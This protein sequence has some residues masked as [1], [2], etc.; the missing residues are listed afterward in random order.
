MMYEALVRLRWKAFLEASSADECDSALDL[1]KELNEVGPTM[2]L[3]DITQQDRFTAILT[4]YQSFIERERLENPT[5]D[6]WSSYIDMV[7]CLLLFLRA[8]REGDWKLHLASLRQ[9]LPWFFAYDRVNYARYLP[10]F[11]SE[12]DN[13]SITHPAIS[14]SF[15]AG[16]FVVQRQDRYGFAQI[17][18]DIAIEQTCN[19][20]SKTKGGMKG[21]TLKKGAVN[22]WLLSHHQ[23]V[24]IMK[25]CKLMAGKDQEG[26]ARKDLDKAR[27]ERDEQDLQN[28][29]ATI[30]AMVNPFENKGEDLI[31]I[32]SGC[33]ASK[34]TRDHLITAYSIGQNGAK[35]FVEDRMTSETDKIFNPIKTNKL[36]T[37]STI[38]K[39]AIA[40]LISETVSLNA[41]SDMFNRL[42]IIGK[43][44]DIDLEELLSY[45]LRTVPMSL[46]TTDGTPCKTVTAKLM[47]ELEKD[48]EPLAQVPAGSA[49]IVDGMAFIHQINTMPS[50][51]GQ[52]AD[53]LLQD[54][55]HM[56]IQ[57]RCLRVDFVCDQYPAQSIKN[58]KR[59]LIEFLFQCW[60]RCDPGI[61]GNVLLIV[62]HGEVC[63]SIV[64]NDAVVAVTEV[65]DLF[66]D[67]EETDTRLLLHAHQ[68]GRAFSS[69]TIKSPDTDV[70]VLSLAKSQY[71]HGCLCFS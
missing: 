59:E 61:L 54:L 49:L 67:H 5:F 27:I 26:R 44:R 1:A 46:G 57:C 56:A 14:D 9:I 39:T 33:V 45:A 13:L 70:M 68:A 66:S 16:D 18:C 4:M 53:R 50:T 28:L 37:F 11:I 58:C 52:L 30:Q 34:Y 15:L 24:A 40:R 29:V 71:F 10:A 7:Q 22:R 19:R 48:V 6:Y 23:R 2:K 21:L 38:G 43:S 3:F 69:V 25:E 42:L 41:S 55:M 32:S 63:H 31:S 8:T 64:V 47:H 60:T 35:S 17:A 12:M 62:S 36:K 65:P 51:F 20:D